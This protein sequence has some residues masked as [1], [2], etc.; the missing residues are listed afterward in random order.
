M[1][2]AITA[3]VLTATPLDG[4]PATWSFGSAEN[5]LLGPPLVV[6]ERVFVTS[7]MG[8]FAIN[9]IDGTL[10]SSDPLEDIAAVEKAYTGGLDIALAAADGLLL[11][12]TMTGLVAY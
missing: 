8:L 7:A 5:E 3:G 1:M 9:R 10:V 6:G 12:P 11:V 2:Y 4:R